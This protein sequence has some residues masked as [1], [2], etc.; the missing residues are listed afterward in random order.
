MDFNKRVDAD[1]RQFIIDNT[2]ISAELYDKHARQQWFI[3]ST[4]MKELGL[5]DCIYGVDDK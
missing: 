1:I 5:I 3:K 4:E 2:N